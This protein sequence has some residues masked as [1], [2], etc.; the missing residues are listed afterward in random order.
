MFQVVSDC[1]DLRSNDPFMFQIV[2][3]NSC[4]YLARVSKLLAESDHSGVQKFSHL[5]AHKRNRRTSIL[6][7]IGV[8]SDAQNSFDITKKHFPKV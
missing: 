3:C 2:P 7:L 5:P 1:S 4:G 8:Q 6:G